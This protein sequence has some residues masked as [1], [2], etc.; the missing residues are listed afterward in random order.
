[1]DKLKKYKKIRKRLEIA[2][3]I[4]SFIIGEIICSF[5]GIQS[6]KFFS[7]NT[8]II[9]AVIC[10]ISLVLNNISIRLADNWY[11]KNNDN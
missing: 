5:F 7:L 10:G 11:E 3:D 6:K 9:I 8:A 1:M 4:I 2:S